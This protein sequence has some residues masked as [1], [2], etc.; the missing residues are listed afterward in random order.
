MTPVISRRALL[1]GAAALVVGITLPARAAE[2]LKSLKDAPDIDAWIQ[3]GADGAVT[4][5]TGKSELGQGIKTALIQVAAEELGL[6]HGMIRL[7]TSDTARTPNEG[8]TAGSH[9]MQDSA[10]AIRQA[11]AAARGILLDE[12]GRRLGVAPESLRLENGAVLAPDGHRVPLGDLVTG[13]RLHA[14]VPETVSLKRPEEYRVVGRS[15]PRIDIPAKVA[16]GAAYV[17]DLRPPGLVHARIVRPPRYGARL[18]KLDAAAVTARPGVIA[19]HRDGDFLAVVAEREYDAVTAMRA[20]ERVATWQGGAALPEPSEMFTDLENLPAERTLIQS[21]GPDAAPEGRVLRARYRRPYQMHASI[22]PSCAL[23]QFADGRLTVW[24]HA[25]GMFPLRQAIAEML[26]LPEETVRCIHAE[27]SGC[28]GHNGADDAAADAAL[29]ARALPGRPVRVQYTRE[30][31]HC[32]EPYGTAM[33][34]D[35]AAV[36][37]PDGRIRSWDYAV[38]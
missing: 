2:G 20:L 38:R 29:L 3:V 1:G 28:Y 33:F 7:V 25:Q 30:Q 27:G 11:A 14:A 37:G 10:S 24:S 8:Y 35:A 22:G 16:G 12:A 15:W 6:E 5:L 17:Q 18:T 21:T 32:W 23:A 9:S 31:E 4:V 19:V 13:E 34:A 36:L 26:G